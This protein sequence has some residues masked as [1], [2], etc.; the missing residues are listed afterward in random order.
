MFYTFS[1]NHSDGYFSGPRYVI[2]E[3]DSGSEANHIAQNHPDSPIYFDGCST[4]QDCRCCGDRWSEVWGEDGKESPEIYGEDDIS[5][6]GSDVLVIRKE[7]KVSETQR[8]KIA[9]ALANSDI[10]WT[11]YGSETIEELAEKIMTALT[12]RLPD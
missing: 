1:Q 10:V 7:T 6:Y 12:N 9:H 3:A 5:R 4:G 11:K 2:I 8:E